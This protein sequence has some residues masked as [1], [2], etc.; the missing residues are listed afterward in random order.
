MDGGACA[1]FCGVHACLGEDALPHMGFRSAKA[2][3][4]RFR[5]WRGSLHFFSSIPI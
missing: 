5:V 4:A 2:L 1:A 3:P